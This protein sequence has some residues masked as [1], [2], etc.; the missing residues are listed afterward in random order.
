MIAS[1]FMGM[2]VMANAATGELTHTNHDGWQTI[3]DVGI[4][5]SP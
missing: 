1:I 4:E 3:S 5:V 2:T